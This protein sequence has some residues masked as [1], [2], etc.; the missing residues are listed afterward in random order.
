MYIRTFEE[1][2]MAI[3]LVQSNSE[4][5]VNDIH[6][7]DISLCEMFFE[8][9]N[10]ERLS[11]LLHIYFSKSYELKDVLKF[12]TSKTRLGLQ[13]K[14]NYDNLTK[15]NREDKEHLRYVPWGIECCLEEKNRDILEAEAILDYVDVLAEEIA[16]YAK[17]D[18]QKVLILNKFMCDHFSYDKEY[19]R[20]RH[21]GKYKDD[22]KIKKASGH[23]MAALIK[24]KSAVCVAFSNFAALV[25]NH[26]RLNVKTTI[27]E[28]EKHAWNKITIEGKHYYYDF[29]NE[30][31]TFPLKLGNCMGK[32]STAMENLTAKIESYFYLIP[33]PKR[34]L[35]VIARFAKERDG[36]KK[37]LKPLG[38]MS[39]RFFSKIDDKMYYNKNTEIIS[40]IDDSKIIK[41]MTLIEDVK[42]EEPINTS[43]K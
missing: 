39:H 3:Q 13:Y 20:K 26:P 30:L 29:T 31:T 21:N 33:D 16:K 17:N 15:I 19:V 8:Q 35:M 42:I 7:F 5:G 27:V 4:I 40:Y 18:R 10:V 37:D 22:L 32:I 2:A 9:V 24:N 38:K 11:S 41:E 25:L 28:S 1:V 36:I 6:F 23:T 14:I 12:A 34:R 43:K